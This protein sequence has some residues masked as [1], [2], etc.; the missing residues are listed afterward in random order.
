MTRDQARRLAD[1]NLD[2]SAKLVPGGDG[3]WGVWHDVLGYWVT[4]ELPHPDD[5]DEAAQAAA[6]IAFASLNL[7]R[8]YL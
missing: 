6:Y 2:Y 7:G 8:D 4:F 3:D 1:I 5:D